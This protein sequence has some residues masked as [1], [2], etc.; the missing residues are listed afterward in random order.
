MAAIPPGT[1]LST[2]PLA[3]NPNGSPPNFVDPPSLANT[4]LGVA[5]PLMVIS[6]ILVGIRLATNFKNT[7]KLGLDDCMWILREAV[8]LAKY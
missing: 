4:I 7:R 5:I 6:T 1:D 8:F 3:P 2:I